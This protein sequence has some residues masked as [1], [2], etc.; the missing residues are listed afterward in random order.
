M[1]KPEKY[2]LENYSIEE[3]FNEKFIEK[4]KS[5]KKDIFPVSVV[6]INE[7]NEGGC[8]K[9]D[10]II[11]SHINK[12]EVKNKKLHIESPDTEI[13]ESIIKIIEGEIKNGK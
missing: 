7:K 2:L 8:L 9:A 1:A 4:L 11:F 6:F 5:L 13:V 12:N 10:P 3:M